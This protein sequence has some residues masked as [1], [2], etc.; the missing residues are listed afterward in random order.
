MI[1]LI[2]AAA[3]GVRV[4]MAGAA[5]RVVAGAAGLEA[6]ASAAVA[7]TVGMMQSAHSTM[8]AV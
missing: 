6:G 2:S 5:A 8:T 1:F 4:M 7:A 3:A